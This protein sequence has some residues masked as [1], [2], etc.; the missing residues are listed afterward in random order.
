MIYSCSERANGVG[1]AQ[2]NGDDLGPEL[3][4]TTSIRPIPGVPARDLRRGGRWLGDRAC[5]VVGEARDPS[6]PRPDRVPPA[7]ISHPLGRPA[8]VTSS[9]GQIE[10]H[11]TVPCHILRRPDRAPPGRPAHGRCRDL[12]GVGCF[13]SWKLEGPLCDKKILIRVFLQSK[14]WFYVFTYHVGLTGGPKLSENVL[15]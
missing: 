1:G 6:P 15:T 4:M 8:P 3:G 9:A 13:F 12:G 14:T 11:L 2:N 7:E 5:A 10:C